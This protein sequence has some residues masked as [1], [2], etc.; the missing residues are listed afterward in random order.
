MHTHIAVRDISSD[1]IKL[2]DVWVHMSSCLSF[3]SC[4]H[5]SRVI[6]IVSFRRASSDGLFGAGEQEARA[7]P[8]QVAG[9]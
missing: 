2:A 9:S 5:V 6:I 1:S 8:K 3:W 4:T 7:C